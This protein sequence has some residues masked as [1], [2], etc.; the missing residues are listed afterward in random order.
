MGAPP[1]I[2]LSTWD[3]ITVPSAVPNSMPVSARVSWPEVD[4]QSGSAFSWS[5]SDPTVVRVVEAGYVRFQATAQIDND[6]A[7]TGNTICW[8]EL[9][10]SRHFTYTHRAPNRSTTVGFDV[11]KFANANEPFR[12]ALAHTGPS[13]VGAD[14]VQLSM[15]WLGDTAAAATTDLFRYVPQIE[16][17]GLDKE[18]N[19]RV[20][21]QLLER[22][23]QIEDYLSKLTA[24]L[25]AGGL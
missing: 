13:S 19:R 6:A 2:V 4:V 1:F 16:Q 3:P 20:I 23:R 21:M 22:D 18:I 14:R 10:N 24:R 12:L 9:Q 8:T 15:T 11:V 7:A 5:A 17:V 25:D